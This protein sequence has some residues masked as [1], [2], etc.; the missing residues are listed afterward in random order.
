MLS[1][2]GR[3]TLVVR[4]WHE[5][6]R[7]AVVLEIND[8]GPGVPTDVQQ[9]IFD[10][11]FT[12]KEVGKGTGLGLTVAYAIVQECAAGLVPV[13]RTADGLAFAAPPL[14]RSGPVEESL[15]EHIA[16]VLGI[17]RAEILDAEWVDNG[18]GWVAVLLASAEAAL[19]VR[20]GLV[21]LDVGEEAG[22]AERERHRFSRPGNG[23]Q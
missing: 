15:V 14:V 19:A 12:N 5:A 3:G 4:T 20:P 21:D 22:L 7:D 17:G 1:A 6:E 9:K 13:R 18:P 16:S 2:H 11:F 8:D 10:P 23:E